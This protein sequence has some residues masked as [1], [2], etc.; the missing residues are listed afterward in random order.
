MR[1]FDLIGCK[2]RAAAAGA[3]T[4]SSTRRVAI[5]FFAD[6]R[7]RP[8]GGGPSS[9]T[10]SARTAA[11]FPVEISLSP[12]EDPGGACWYRAPSATSPSA[13]QFEKNVAEQEPRSRDR[14]EMSSTRF[15]YSVSHDLQ[16]PRCGPSTGSAVILPPASICSDLS[17]EGREYLE[18]VRGEHGVQMG[19]LVDDLLAFR[20]TGP[21][22]P[23]GA[24][25]F[26]QVLGA[27]SYSGGAPIA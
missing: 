18:L 19:R 26:D 9:S 6:P 27:A 12:L 1:G 23:C 13:S 21:P 4:A 20:T 11:S 3:A 15:S 7:V 8:M 25:G 16:R 24:A 5:V 17:P 14:R 10:A 22:N 2:V